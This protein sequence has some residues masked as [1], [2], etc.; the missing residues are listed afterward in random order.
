MPRRVGDW[1]A[2]NRG[3]RRLLADEYAR[4]AGVPKAWMPDEKKVTPFHA[5]HTTCVNISEAVAA[6]LTDNLC[7]KEVA[8][9]PTNDIS[10]TEG[11]L[12]QEPVAPPT[13]EARKAWSWRPTNCDHEG[14]KLHEDAIATV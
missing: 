7:R 8:T 2:T 11:S 4:G 12:S 5:E 3:V 1:I 9:Q 6:N 14:G 13:D 10:N